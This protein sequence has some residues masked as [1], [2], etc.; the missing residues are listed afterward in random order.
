MAHRLVQ[1]KAWCFSMA[2][3]EKGRGGSLARWEEE[4]KLKAKF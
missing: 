1:R 2:E 3:D 4:C